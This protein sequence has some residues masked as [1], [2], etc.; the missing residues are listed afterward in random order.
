VPNCDQ[1]DQQPLRTNKRPVYEVADIFNL[2]FDEYLRQHRVSYWQQKIVQAIRECRTA[3]LGAHLRRCDHCG[4]EEPAYNS[5]RNRH[6]PKCQGRQKE[7]WV[8]ARLEELLPVGYFHTVFTLTS[9]LHS[10]MY[11]NQRVMYTI[12]FQSAAE[13]LRTFAA[14]PRYLGGKIGFIGILHT[15]GQRLQYHPHIH[16][17]I[18]GGG[19]TEDDKQ[20]LHPKHG[21]KFLFP[22]KA[23]SQVM[24][25]KFLEKL[26]K[27]YAAGELK[28]AGKLAYLAKPG[29]FK[30]FL[31][32]LARTA[33]VIRSKAPFANPEEVV[34]AVSQYSQQG[35]MENGRL[36]EIEPNGAEEANSNA[37]PIGEDGAIA[38]DG[39]IH[40]FAKYAQRV[41][42]TNGRLVAIE[43]G[44]I[45]FRFKNNLKGGKAEVMT[46]PA[47]EFIRRFLWHILPKG[48][49]KI[50]HYGLLSGRIKK[51][52]LAQ[53]RELLSHLNPIQARQTFLSKWEERANR[54]PR[55]RQGKMGF[56]GVL[57]AT[58]L[59]IYKPLLEGS[60]AVFD[61]S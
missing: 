55:C 23:M 59:E 41:G 47:A 2:Y 24:R 22:D 60:R 44:Q 48:F 11:G 27:A 1:I 18:T 21:Q 14:D 46:L 53:A 56:E 8:K 17:I 52:Y 10:L 6:C 50:R 49:H 51:R 13:T 39:V 32:Q 30:N 35:A 26:E 16:F 54:C 61:T 7:E 28:L 9:M 58:L 42:I 15:W 43:A 31:R 25:G 4:Y 37:D 33:F 34:T 38:A 19:L 12:F 5:C 36:A 29:A 3:V 40:Y 45:R 20:W 57:S